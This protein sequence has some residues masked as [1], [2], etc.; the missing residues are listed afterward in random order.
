MERQ[1]LT[2]PRWLSQVAP[3]SQGEGTPARAHARTHTAHSPAPP[4]AESGRDHLATSLLSI[5]ACSLLDDVHETPKC[6][7]SALRAGQAARWRHQ[8]CG[9]KEPQKP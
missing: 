5:S 7:G 9:Q 2:G 4:S 8:L 3:I 6:A 1:V